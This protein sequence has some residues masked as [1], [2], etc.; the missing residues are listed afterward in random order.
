MSVGPCG[1][2][3][4]TWPVANQQNLFSSR[5]RSLF[6]CLALWR[7]Q[8][9]WSRPCQSGSDRLAA[10]AVS[11]HGH[12][13][14]QHGNDGKDRTDRHEN[15]R[16]AGQDDGNARHETEN[17][18]KGEG[19]M[20]LRKHRALGGRRHGV[21]KA[22]QPKRRPADE[23]EM[24]MGHGQRMIPGD[25][26]LDAPDHSGRRTEHGGDKEIESNI[27]HPDIPIEKR[28]AN[29]AAPQRL[30]DKTSEM[31]QYNQES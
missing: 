14:D 22:E 5:C 13:K 18:D 26:H 6:S 25:R 20:H 11:R 12:E 16:A 17:A 30:G 21:I 27:F 28:P 23:V 29:G 3:K 1:K 9:L 4:T 10:D 19:E 31:R 8:G 7:G 2:T 15:R 24:G